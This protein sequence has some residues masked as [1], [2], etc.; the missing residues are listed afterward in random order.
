MAQVLTRLSLDL[1]MERVL[2]GQGA[3]PV[4]V[5]PR[6]SVLAL[7]GE[8]LAEAR[9]LMV[10]VAV[11]ELYLLREIRHERLILENGFA[12][13]AGQAAGRLALA[14]E[15]A[16]LVGTI[17]CQLEERA[18]QYFS[19]GHPARGAVLD[20]IGST[21]VEELI[22]G[23]C[24]VIEERAAAK[25]MRTS[26][27]FSPGHNDWPLDAQKQIF[28]LLPTDKIG[29]VLSPSCLMIPRKSL[30][31]VVGL[32]KEFR[33]DGRSACDICSIRTTCRYRRLSRIE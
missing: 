8:I 26:A 3:D 10:P 1:D 12:L 27:P 20:S 18:S 17:G 16:V 29:V 31:M 32:G 2:R 11:Y 21:A 7:I 33:A 30:S 14:Q 25:G 6:E 22:E 5:R 19:A 28:E 24:R 4:I 23:A 9:Q 15:I 13:C